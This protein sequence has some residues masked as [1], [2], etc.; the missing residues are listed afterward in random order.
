MNPQDIVNNAMSSAMTSIAITVGISLLLTVVVIVFVRR[1]IGR[2]TGADLRTS[3][4]TAKATILRLWDTGTTVN[5]NPVA[6]ML[7]EVQPPSGQ[8]YQVE[9][10][11]LIPRLATAQVQ[12]GAVIQVKIDPAKRERVVVDLFAA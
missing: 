8:P 5:D 2:M 11:S 1:Y 4:I 3:G 12:P 10:K 7:L 6:G 9:T